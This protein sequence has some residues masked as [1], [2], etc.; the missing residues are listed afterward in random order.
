MKTYL[1]AALGAILISTTVTNAQTELAPDQNPNF[2]VSRAKYMAMADSLNTWHSTTHQ[3]MYK[4]IDW[5][6]DRRQ[7]RV[8][9]REFRRQLRLERARWGN[10]YYYD[11]YTPGFRNGWGNYNYYYNNRY[12]RRSNSLFLHPWGFGYWWR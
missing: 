9:R 12:Y 11:Y 3:E 4:A 7:A 6:E 8:D 10:D 2:A 1:L 5:L